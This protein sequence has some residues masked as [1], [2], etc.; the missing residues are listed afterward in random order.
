[1][2]WPDAHRLINVIRE[3]RPELTV[4]HYPSTEGH[5]AVRVYCILKEGRRL[6]RESLE[7]VH[8]KDGWARYKERHPG[9]WCRPEESYHTDHLGREVDH[10]GLPV[11]I[12]P[13]A[14]ASVAAEALLE[15]LV[16]LG[17]Q[18]PDW[19]KRPEK[20]AEVAAVWGVRVGEY[21]VMAD[22]EVEEVAR[23]SGECHASVLIARTGS[24]LFASGHAARWQ[25]GS[26]LMPP[27]ILS[28]PFDSEP[29]ARRAALKRLIEDLGAGR[30]TGEREA[31]L[32][33]VRDRERSAGLFG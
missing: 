27:S 8:G 6:I 1:M 7:T 17:R 25:G 33:A 10:R 31:L 11:R 23:V 15:R 19:W 2:R 14:A 12:E 24:G 21:G 3:E 9:P 26:S 4:D 18:D 30:Q 16:A 22:Y 28:V 29:E 5:Y 20:V 13:P 32:G